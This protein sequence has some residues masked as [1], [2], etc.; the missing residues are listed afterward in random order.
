MIAAHAQ[1][2]MR[3]VPR[4]IAS[5][6]SPSARSVAASANLDASPPSR[7]P[8]TPS[9]RFNAAAASASRPTMVTA[10]G[11][12]ARRAGRSET[13]GSTSGGRAVVAKQAT[14][15]VHRE[16]ARGLPSQHRDA[17]IDEA[18]EDQQ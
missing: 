10:V 2:A 14:L 8:T 16:L 12:R 9:A 6:S 18:E 13:E 3:N 7:T 4:A 15:A 1:L 11:R 17:E 5:A